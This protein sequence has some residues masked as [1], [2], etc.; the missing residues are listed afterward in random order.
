MHR[1]TMTRNKCVGF[2]PKVVPLSLC[3]YVSR[4]NHDNI[5]ITYNINTYIVTGSTSNTWNKIAFRFTARQLQSLDRLWLFPRVHSRDH[6][7]QVRLAGNQ[8]QDRLCPR[9]N[10]FHVSNFVYKR[11]MRLR[12]YLILINPLV[13]PSCRARHASVT[14]RIRRRYR[15]GSRNSWR[16]RELRDAKQKDAVK[17]WAV[18]ESKKSA[19][20]AVLCSWEP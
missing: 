19:L 10:G 7:S 2:F 3:S 17:A 13:A 11:E 9:R 18:C 16:R 20:K 12:R 6:E 14:L 4:I 8:A 5:Y 15:N 1:K